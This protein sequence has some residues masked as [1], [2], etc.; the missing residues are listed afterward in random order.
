MNRSDAALY[1]AGINVLLAL[2]ITAPIILAL[3]TTAL[4]I[5]ATRHDDP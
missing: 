2:H 4:L 5:E 1:L 3:V